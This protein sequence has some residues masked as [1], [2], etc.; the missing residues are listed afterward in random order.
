[1]AAMGAMIGLMA[2]P[3]GAAA[4]VVVGSMLDIAAANDK[5][6]D[7]VKTANSALEFQPAA[8]EQN[9][10]AIESARQSLED[11]R[12]AATFGKEDF[13]LKAL[14]QPFGGL[15]PEIKNKIEGIF[16]DSDVEEA[17]RQVQ[18]LESQYTRMAQS[19]SDL[20]VVMGGTEIPTDDYAA[21]ERVVSDL[22]PAFQAAGYNIND[23][24]G[25]MRNASTQVY[26]WA[27]HEAIEEGLQAAD[28]QT[29]DT[30][31]QVQDFQ[32]AMEDA[33]GGKLNVE[34]A[35]LAWRDGLAA[36]RK[37][38][39]EGTATLDANTQEGRDNR[40]AILDQAKATQ[41]YVNA[42]KEAG[43]P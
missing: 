38:L 18:A 22:G 26:G 28:E 41:D 24:L 1:N 12:E 3:W 14:I 42:L 33:F 13:N 4:G 34:E 7:A 2:G 30:I 11:F 36:L 19:I 9:S 21:L 43:A 15:G 29:D 25:L 27:I 20:N 16:G 31:N 17:E 8:F 39:K 40:K 35:F 37:E 6:A 10:V 32:S 23:R 5:V